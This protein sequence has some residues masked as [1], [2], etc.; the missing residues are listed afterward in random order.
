MR[1]R[2]QGNYKVICSRDPSEVPFLLAQDDR[3]IEEVRDFLKLI[4]LRGF[5]SKT[6][7]AYAYDLLVFYRFLAEHKISIPKLSRQHI[8]D[9]ILAHRR[10]NAAPRTINRRIIVIRDFLN[11]RFENLGDK[12]LKQRFHPF[13]K[14]RKNKALLGPSRIKNN[15]TKNTLSVKVPRTLLNPLKPNEIKRFLSNLRTCRD[16]SMIYL[17]LFCG[18]RSHEILNLEIYHIDFVDNK[19]TV[20]GKGLKQRII[21]MPESVRKSLDQYINH[22]RPDNLPH[23]K[24]F[25]VLK[26]TSKGKP[27]TKE[28]LRKIFRYHRLKA[29]LP[30][31]HPH[32]FRHTFCS[33][34]VSKGVALPI[35]QKLMG[36]SSIDVTLMY[37]HMGLE[38]VAKEFHKATSLLQ[39]LHNA[40]TG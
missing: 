31:A 9:F 18:L 37:V 36:H 25:T 12:L 34:L 30:R 14:G 23:Q 13:Y 15:N 11:D 16:Q 26:K 38:D 7:R 8:I 21:P 22:E 29:A 27:L 2:I 4:Y 17:M 35:V 5:S 20:N 3:I 6:V 28:G 33:N 10:K 19:I 24:L 40:D 39:K 1:Q 32:L